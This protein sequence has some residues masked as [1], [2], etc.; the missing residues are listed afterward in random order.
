MSTSIDPTASSHPITVGT[1]AFI[2]AQHHYYDWMRR[3][4]PVYRGK[5]ALYGDQDV[6]FLSRYRDCL[7]AVTDRRIRRV[8]AGAEPPPL[9]KALRMLTTDTMI[10]QD[11]PEHLRLR[12]LVS[13]S[14]TPRAVGRLTDRVEAVTRE[15]LDGMESG[16]QIDL[17]QAYALPVPTTVINEMVG[18]PAADRYRFREF[19]EVLINGMSTYGL[20]GAAERTEGAIDYVRELVQRRR[21][22]PG[23]DIL[24]ELVHACEEGESLSDDEVIA[25]VFLLIAAG[26]ETTYNLITNGVAALLTHPDQ[27]ALL[28]ERP[29]LIDSAVEE[30]LRYTGTVGGTEATTYAIEDITWHGVTIPRGSLV[31]ALLASANRDPAEF[32][33]PDAFDITRSPNNHLAFSKGNHFCL[34]AHLARMETRIAI[35]NLIARFPRLSLAVDAAELTLLPVPLLNRLNGLPVTLS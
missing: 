8:V 9:P 7:E 15:L 3:T 28:R 20:E 14:F 24:T 23:E 2:A 16:Q 22:E 30:M 29:A 19:V 5:L 32:D 12:K 17:Q 18:V 10:Y 6:Y 4:A 11:D 13:R 26:Y 27:L 1:S 31:M 21:A 33:R 35:G 34:G 25:M